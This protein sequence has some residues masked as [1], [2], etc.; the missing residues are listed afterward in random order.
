MKNDSRA[1]E[2]QGWHSVNAFLA[3]I[4][5]FGIPAVIAASCNGVTPII[6]P[7]PDPS[8]PQKYV[9]AFVDRGSQVVRVLHSEDGAD[10]WSDASFPNVVPE[11]GLGA[12]YDSDDDFTY[13]FFVDNSNRLHIQPSAVGGG[14]AESRNID[15]PDQVLSA[16]AVAYMGSRNFLVAYRTRNDVL[17]LRWFDARTDVWIEDNFAPSGAKVS[18]DPTIAMIG[19]RI[20]LAWY[21]D[22]TVLDSDGGQTF[23]IALGDKAG[24]SIS[25]LSVGPFELTDVLPPSPGTPVSN[26][27]L[28]T[29]GT[30]FLLGV[31]FHPVG[32]YNLKILSSDN[33]T[34]WASRFGD[35]T[36]NPP[37][38]PDGSGILGV[39]AT[40]G[41]Q[42]LAMVTSDLARVR[43]HRFNP[44]PVP[45]DDFYL[46][47]GAVIGNSKNFVL[48]VNRR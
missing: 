46:P 40:A 22:G 32:A 8:I 28:T 9:V 41:G 39:A 10:P 29:D 26:L 25:W 33:G 17:A 20:V 30:Q 14:W 12:T 19:E 16:P 48:L 15:T 18:G 47:W 43:V 38:P 6:P 44:P 35:T 13:I 11:V 34:V 21:G 42:V 2:E 37:G 27:V 1:S 31:I 45:D 7:V 24:I 36:E 5:M 3:R 4:V 23:N